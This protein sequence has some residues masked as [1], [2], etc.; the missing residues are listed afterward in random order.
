MAR[1]HV[2]HLGKRK[3]KYLD[4]V[5]PVA[6]VLYNEDGTLALD[7]D[8]DPI[9]ETADK[10]YHVP[11]RSSLTMGEMLLFN[12][13]EGA[14]NLDSIATF[15]NFLSRHIPREVVLELDSTDIEEFYDEWD[16]ASRE[17]EGL[18]QGE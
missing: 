1:K 12:Q 14:T 2:V 13:P 15:A 17:D 3:R 9:T 6:S 11:L 5:I 8:M 10:I 16:K 7:E 4:V 18:T